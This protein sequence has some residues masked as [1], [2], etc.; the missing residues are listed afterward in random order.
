MA[1]IRRRSTP[2][3]HSGRDAEGESR[4]STD[5]PKSN[6]P[7]PVAPTIPFGGE[8]SR[9][10]EMPPPSDFESALQYLIAN[11][12]QSQQTDEESVRNGLQRIFCSLA[13]ELGRVDGAARLHG[14][15]RMETLHL[16]RIQMLDGKGVTLAQHE[17]GCTCEAS[18][19]LQEEVEPN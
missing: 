12:L 16:L 7:A 15:P 11:F 5:R 14:I 9:P 1:R 6:P 17:K 2:S 3:R 13:R 10:H 4:M 19:V 8:E 18:K